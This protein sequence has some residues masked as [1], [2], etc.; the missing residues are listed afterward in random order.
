MSYFDYTQKMYIKLV[1]SIA[2]NYKTYSVLDYCQAHKNNSLQDS[3]FII[4]HDVDGNINNALSMAKI[5]ADYGIRATYYFRT[6]PFFLY[7]PDIMTKVAELGHE[8]GYHY[9]MLSDAM[10]NFIKARKMFKENLEKLRNIAPVKTVCM[11]GRPFSKYDNI[12]FWKRYSLEE[13]DLVGEPYLTIDYTDKY[14]FSDTGLCWNNHRFN[15]RDIVK[16]KGN[17]DI[18][19]TPQLIDFINT[20]DAKRAAVLTHTNI[21]TDSASILMFY[22][23][24]FYVINRIKYYKKKQMVN[25]HMNASND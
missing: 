23:I 15:L 4:R 20:P 25:T 16:S 9:E 21:W 14:Y 10:G 5:D 2:N 6:K 19:S 1:K 12:D 3:Y 18:G 13:F 17:L 24:V 11:H 8:I 22:K 7:R